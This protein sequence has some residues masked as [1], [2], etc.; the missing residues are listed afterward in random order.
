MVNL[1]GIRAEVVAALSAA[2][3][4]AVDYI[5]E[6]M[7]PPVAAVVPGD[8]YLDS[9]GAT[10]GHTNVNLL[11][12]LIGGKGTNKAAASQ[13]DSLIATALDALDDWDITEVAQPG[14]VNL[15]GSNYLGSV[16]TISSET[17]L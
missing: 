15:N 6:T 5:G 14:L 2:D 8:P 16:I 17:K 9:E 7:T 11:I 13:I 4:K 1:E 3:I 12:L 10:F